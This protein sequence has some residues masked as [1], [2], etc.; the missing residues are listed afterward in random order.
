LI[1]GG[2]D[3]LKALQ[4]YHSLSDAI[5]QPS[6]FTPE[7]AENNSEI[8]INAYNQQHRIFS[9][10]KKTEQYFKVP[11]NHVMGKSRMR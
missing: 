11:R 5:Q 1:R 3:K 7:E 10:N 8:I 2:P 6:G 9:R 4:M